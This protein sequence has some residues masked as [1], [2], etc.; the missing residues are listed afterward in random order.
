MVLDPGA[1]AP[2]LTRD[3]QRSYLGLIAKG[4]S[5]AGACQQLG[6]HPMSVAWT[7]E[8]DER[9]RSLLHRVNELLSQNVAAALYRSAMEGSVPAQ[10]FYLKNRPPPDWSADTTDAETVPDSQDELTD[11]ELLAQ[12]RQ[13]ALALLDQIEQDVEPSAGLPGS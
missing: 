13:E 3:Q 4:A 12:F 11:D 9:F 5:P 8:E 10:T 1:E 6:L 7:T 2:L